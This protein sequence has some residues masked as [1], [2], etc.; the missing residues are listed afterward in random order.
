MNEN[1]IE[2]DESMVALEKRLGISRRSF[3]QMCAAMAATMGLPNDADAA[4]VKAVATKKRPSV[5]WLHFQECTGCTES[6]LRAEHPTLEKLILDVISL[7]YHET[8]FAAAGHQAEAA[9]KSAMKANKGKYLLVVEGAIPTKDNG[10]YCKIG[11]QTAIEM[12]KE[13]AADAAAVIAI[14]SCASWGG[15]PSTPPNPT[16]AKSAGEVLGK[17]IPNIPGCPPNPYNFL[18]TVVHFLTF[19]K[20]PDVDDKGRPKF[21]YSRLIHENCERR[22]HFDAGRF[23]HGVRRRGSPQGLLPV[24]AGLQRS[25]DLCQLPGDPV[26]RCR[27]CQL[28]GRHRSPVHRLYREGYRV[29][30]TYP[31]AGRTEDQCGRRSGFPRIVEEQGKG[32][33]IGATVL[34]AAVAGAAAGAGA[35][36]AKNLGKN[37][38]LDEGEPRQEA[39]GKERIMSISRRDF[40]KGALA[41]GTL[42]ATGAPAEARENKTMPDEALGLLYDSTLC[43]GCKA[44]VS[45]CKEVN[46]M[47]PEFSTED[48]LWD[49][50]LDI[51]GKTLNV[52]K[53]YKDGNR[54]NQGQRERRL[55]LHEGVLPALRRSVLRVGLPGVGD[56]QGSGHR[57]RRLRQGRLHRLP[58]LRGRMPVRRAALPVR[59]G[60]AAD[61]QMPAVPPPH[62]GRQVC[63]LRG[64]VPDRRDAVRQ[65]QGSARR[66]EASCGAEARRGR[67]VPAR[68]HQHAR[69]VVAHCQ[70]GEISPADLR[71]EG[72][73]RHP[74]AE[75]VRRAVREAGHAEI[76]GAIL[77]VPHPKPCS[78][79]STAG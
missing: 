34:T 30:Q 6:L 58:L 68:Q 46:D 42:L 21:A 20:L 40:L 45:A 29:H 37:V 28:A 69:P 9:R 36:M 32:A 62:A 14:G 15:M 47:P 43:I 57:H 17:V 25:G 64:S 10:I 8:L 1:S 56:D 3:L 26:R 73:R 51:S 13:C 38:K 33:S 75:A 31:C 19:G 61:Q 52:I 70:G 4:M 66:S 74:D 53:V 59:Q 18:S 79:R 77:R 22:A 67:R 49:T 71:R 16:G 76:A 48:Q 11:G 35:M 65:G 39:R 44:C 54:R 50:P 23:A 5:I 63:R 55:C 78:T 27:Q 60:V 2:N 24:Q 41:G 7:D 12:L 72:S